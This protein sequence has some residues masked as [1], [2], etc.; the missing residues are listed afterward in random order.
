M[1]NLCILDS[2]NFEMDRKVFLDKHQ[3]DDDR[4]RMKQMGIYLTIPFLLAVP[5]IIGWFI[6]KWMDGELNTSF[7]K[8]LG[9]FLGLIAGFREFY[10]IVK[11]FGDK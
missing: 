8:Y 2:N 3:N 10:R 7:I 9:V 4:K 5:P 6:G 11:R 1:R